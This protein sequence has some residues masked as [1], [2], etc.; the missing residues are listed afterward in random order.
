MAVTKPYVTF[1]A[2]A[3]APVFKSHAR[4]VLFGVGL[5]F[6]TDRAGDS[7]YSSH[8]TSLTLSLTKSL[9][10]RNRNKIGFGFYGGF[11]QRTI[12]YA[13]LYF[14]EQFVNG[15][16]DPNNPISEDFGREKFFFFD[17]GIGTFYSYAP[18]E[19]FSLAVGVSASH[20]NQPDQSLYFKKSMLPIKTLVHFS[21]AIRLNKIVFLSPMAFAS[22][23]KEYREIVF[24]TNLTY[25]FKKNSYT[26][27]FAIGVG[28]FYRWAD[29]VIV[30]TYIEWQNLKFGCSYDLNS[31]TLTRASQVRGGFEFSL[32]YI[33]KKPKIYKI[34]KEPCPF[35]IF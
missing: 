30:N 16:F 3:D 27:R 5:N 26:D 9:D 1:S 14:D 18:S 23:Q 25:I 33:Y 35:E 4:R 11:V 13:A 12:N 7:K 2:A 15:T 29:A 19:K 8:Q 6:S 22:F 21:T 31:S 10:R 34:G 24:G 17:C 28:L 32:S 20:L